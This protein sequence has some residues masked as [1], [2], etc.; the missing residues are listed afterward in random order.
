MLGTKIN[1]VPVWLAYC[2]FAFLAV[3]FE[4]V[5]GCGKDARARDPSVRHYAVLGNYPS[6]LY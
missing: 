4:V 3:L 6:V 2:L 5:V 1:N